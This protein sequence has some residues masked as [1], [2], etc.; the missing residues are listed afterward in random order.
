MQVFVICDIIVISSMNRIR[1]WDMSE[2]DEKLK[3]ACQKIYYQIVKGLLSKDDTIL[4]ENTFMQTTG[5]Y[6][7][8]EAGENLAT[9]SKGENVA[10]L[11]GI[12]EN[13]CN[14]EYLANKEIKKFMLEKGYIKENDGKIEFL[15]SFILQTPKNNLPGACTKLDKNGNILI[16][17]HEQQAKRSDGSLAVAL[18]HEICHQMINKE[19]QNNG[20]S[21]EVEA[22][23]DIVGLIAAK[24][25]GYDIKNKI[26]E[27]EKDYSRETQKKAIEYFCP[28]MSAKEIEA[29]V[30][31]HME[32]TVNT[33][34]MPEKLIKIAKF[35][36]EK[37]PLSI[38]MKRKRKVKEIKKRI[39]AKKS[40]P[41][42]LLASDGKAHKISGNSINKAS[43]NSQIALKEFRDT[44][45]L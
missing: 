4:L 34:Y 40:Q 1:F 10:K 22:L 26:L 23:C 27:D 31:E 36:D 18:G 24:G 9:I 45:K 20:T 19:T 33:F 2:D 37:V 38:K 39:I 44:Q 28:N 21:A 29:K 30:D 7:Y 32:K 16:I 25:A 11:Q 3:K 17:V 15:P 41:T 14:G 43:I 35:V 8:M 6:N 13:L 5:K 12:I 42:N